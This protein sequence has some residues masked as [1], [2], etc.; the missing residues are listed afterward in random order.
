M[1]TEINYI[2]ATFLILFSSTGFAQVKTTDIENPYWYY[3]FNGER[4]EFEPVAEEIL[5]EFKA[6]AESSAKIR[7]LSKL[8][9][10]YDALWKGQFKTTKE[11]NWSDKDE[12]L[13][14]NT[15][16]NIL[17][18]EEILKQ[19]SEI[20]G[21]LPKLKNKSTGEIVE[22]RPATFDVVFSQD[23]PASEIKSFLNKHHLKLRS[24]P[25]RNFYSYHVMRFVHVEIPKGAKL[26][27]IIRKIANEPEVEHAF[28][29]LRQGRARIV[30]I[31][32]LISSKKLRNDEPSYFAK[33]D[34]PCREIY[35]LY[36]NSPSQVL[37]IY[38]DKY[39]VKLERNEIAVSILL[40]DDFTNNLN[41]LQAVEFDLEKV[42]K[43][44]ANSVFHGSLSI[45]DI[46]ECAKQEAVAR[47]F[48]Q[49][50]DEESHSKSF[51][52][53]LNNPV[54]SIQ[55]QNS[56]ISKI[57][58][59][60][61]SEGVDL[62]DAD[63]YHQNGIYGQNVK[64]GIIDLGF[65]SYQSLLGTELPNSVIT[66]SF[67]DDSG[68]GTS[69][70]GTACAEIIH[71]VAPE[72]ELYFAIVET[73]NDYSDAINWLKNQG[74]DIMSISNLLINGGPND[75]TGAINDQLNIAAAQNFNLFFAVSAGN[76]G[77]KHYEDYFNGYGIDGNNQVTTDDFHN[78]T[79][80]DDDISFNA[81]EN[82]TI[83]VDLGWYD[84]NDPN[85]NW[86]STTEDLDLFLAAGIDE[87]DLGE[88]DVVKFSD[89]V[90]NSSSP[91]P[92]KE[93]I[94]YDVPFGSPTLHIFVQDFPLDPPPV[95]ANDYIIEVF[96]TPQ[97]TTRELDPGIK[98]PDGSIASPADNF[99]ACTAGSFYATTNK[100]F[101][102]FDKAASN[103]R[104]P[105][106]SGNISK[107]D[108]FGPAWVS[109]VSGGTFSG[110]S[111]AAP[112]VAGAA[113]LLIES[114]RATTR[115]Q[116]DDVLCS[117]LPGYTTAGNLL[118]SQSVE[119]DINTNKTWSTGSIINVVG[120]DGTG[121]YTGEKELHLTIGNTLTI[122]SGAII[123][124]FDHVNFV[125]DA[126][127]TLVIKS[128]AIISFEGDAEIIC[129]GMCDDQNGQFSWS[130]LACILA[131][132]G[133]VYKN[134]SSNTLIV[135]NGAFL[136]MQGGTYELPDAGTVFE[137]GSYWNIGP[138]STI[139]V[140]PSRNITFKA[141][142][143][144]NAVGTVAQPII[145]TSA[146]GT[147]SR[148]EWG[149]LFIYSSNNTFEHCIVE[150]SDWGL[151]FYGTPSPTTGNVVKNS[152]LHTNDQAIRAENTELDVYDCTIEDN[153]HAFVLI[154][155]TSQNGG[156]Y[157]DGN[158]VRNNDRDG[159]YS[160]N[161]VVDIFNTTLDNNGLGNVSTYH[162]IWAVTSSDIALGVR[163]FSS[164]SG[165]YN[166]IKNNHGA[167]IY[168]SSSSYLLGGYYVKPWMQQAGQNSIYGNGTY[169]GTYNG[170][171][172]YNLNIATTYA[173]KIYW[174]SPSGPSPGQ[175]YGPVDYSYWLSSPPI[176]DPFKI[177]PSPP[178]VLQ[179]TNGTSGPQGLS[180]T[181]NAQSADGDKDLK[182]KLIAQFKATI[183]KDPGSQQAVDA[184]QNLYSFVRTD[185]QDKLG[186][187]SR[188]YGYLNGLSNAHPNL[189]IGEIAHQLMIVDNM[190]RENYDDAISVAEAAPSGG[191][192]EAKRDVMVHLISLY[193]RTGQ[194][195]KAEN[196]FETFKTVFSGDEIYKEFLQDM[197]KHVDQDL[198][199]PIN[200]S[201]T[202]ASL[203]ELS[204]SETIE[205]ETAIPAIFELKQNYPNPF[206]PTTIIGYSVHEPGF[207]RLRIF[208]LTGAEINTLYNGHKSPGTHS[209]VWDGTDRLGRQ[210][211]SGVYFYQITFQPTANGS[212][213][214][215]RSRK[216]SLLR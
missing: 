55:N 102:I 6:K 211:S 170:K 216:L 147:P 96:T 128:G 43:L 70:H 87:N 29:L 196:Q 4:I 159:I 63:I 191:S 151:K 97:F 84:P 112:H 26:F 60:V 22:F 36:N 10:N 197:F 177:A 203:P 158:T 93:K 155:N 110:T 164:N 78:F 34:T 213:G 152:H 89:D 186:Q 202:T 179:E 157:L 106:N 64:I 167:G 150:G 126:G 121:I 165:G 166:T 144:I 66:Q 82:K 204:D 205:T 133:G 8:N 25:I 94:E 90:Q 132:D 73:A 214:F 46:A 85:F 145:F 58:S 13:L 111:A 48:V 5:V 30:Q 178:H 80:S 168:R 190:S 140:Q 72:A 210:V 100:G 163:T 149:T 174:G 83:N 71:D 14:L 9:E 188:I 42:G 154:N 107:P 116:I 27:S 19:E 142:A 143:Y 59:V 122:Q 104:G 12:V 199:Q 2:C 28:P 119:D 113:A 192:L 172:I 180:K 130:P 201:N 138:G 44:G 92:G 160:I 131:K 52:S 61:I 68:L 162:G 194:I 185:W 53:N 1:K 129:E 41:I 187:R 124:L 31:I 18:T 40:N 206:N 7:A 39:N 17:K 198:A 137:S 120:Y 200:K 75:G 57:S 212:E 125:I 109:T 182:K 51:G 62:I 183:A 67:R 95:D 32:N 139:K 209:V 23:I 77:E 146:D 79:F 15:N 207:V 35:R 65:A 56:R 38:K 98:V 81:T 123:T 33:L 208:D 88:G 108:V 115:Q 173:H 193:L 176:D 20:L 105:S 99:N 169:S 134:S 136:A 16:A 3:S 153:R 47:V 195:Q 127:A 74:V 103:S 175:F 148:S 37:D 50:H 24:D 114:G 45:K 117:G 135:D 86:Y 215:T 118:L 184:L 161:S 54:E 141:G 171:D 156:I 181:L 101:N 49:Y 189:R 21:V 11:V 69:D 76:H 91:A